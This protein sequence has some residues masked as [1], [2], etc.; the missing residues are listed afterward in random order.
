MKPMTAAI[1]FGGGA[2]AVLAMRRSAE[3]RRTA[4]VDRLVVAGTLQSK[5]AYAPPAGTE[6]SGVFGVGTIDETLLALLDKAQSRPFETKSNVQVDASSN[7]VAVAVVLGVSLVAAT[8]LF[9]GG[10][11]P[12]RRGRRRPA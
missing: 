1:L 5:A 4:D 9:S 8:A 3:A 11:R 6:H 10:R 7:I 2:L 12:R